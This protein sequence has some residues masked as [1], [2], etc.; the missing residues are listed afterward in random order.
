M[1]EI[2]TDGVG[3]KITMALKTGS[4]VD[5]HE[6]AT[7][8]SEAEAM[9]KIDSVTAKKASATVAI[10]GFGVL[11]NG[12]AGVRTALKALEDKDALLL[13]SVSSSN[14]N[15][16]EVQISS[17]SVAKAGKTAIQVLALA[18]PE[19]TEVHNAAGAVFSSASQA[20]SGLTTVTLAVDGTSRAIPIGTAT[21]QGFVDAINAA[22]FAGVTARTMVKAATGGTVS[23]IVQGKTGL[24]NAFTIG[25]NL[26]GS[27]EL[28]YVQEQAA[29]NLK[30]KVNN[31]EEI[32]RDNNSPADVI[33]GVQIICKTSNA[34]GATRN[35]VVSENTSGLKT[36]ID[37]FITAYNDLLT[38]TDYLTGDKDEEDELAGSL[39]KDKR[40]VNS[41]ISRSR[42][43]IGLASESASNGF[44]TFRDIGISNDLSGKISLNES[45]YS[46]ALKT[47][48]SDI[49]TM[50]TG[51]TNDQPATSLADRGLALQSSAILNTMI[52]TTGSITTGKVNAEQSV[53][54][55]TAEL[56][57]LQE[58][59]ENSKKRYL[60][61][62]AAMEGLVQRS[63]NTQDYLTSQFKAMESM[64]SN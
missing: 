21:P 32:Y 19:V 24:A 58:R 39:V 29:Q 11:K 5:I 4:G 8:L 9:P 49:R 13:N 28:S 47:N 30:L 20:I 1:A 2:S 6:L 22:N 52:D 34:D 36:S 7:S 27:A 10:S 18:R 15:S 3:S 55:Y 43:L 12:V 59:L 42:E 61:Q 25:T 54:K 16:V 62:F 31:V 38:L 57:E 50:L 53:T 37:G 33:D 14:P 35:I 45:V 44:S 41:L 56:L 64:Y 63:K 23:I 17:Q 60:A 51:D 26:S 40:T 46:T 48:F